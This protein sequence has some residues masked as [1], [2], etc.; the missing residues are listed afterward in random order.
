M[1][2][3]IKKALS[4]EKGLYD[5]MRMPKARRTLAR[6]YRVLLTQ[7]SQ[8]IYLLALITACAPD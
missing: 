7:N 5:L 1:E 4:K 8:H 6:A 3:E 2:L